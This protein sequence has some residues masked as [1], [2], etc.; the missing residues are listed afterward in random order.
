M[1][2]KIL[3]SIAGLIVLLLLIGF[4]LPARLHISKSVSIHAPV[5]AVFE[6]INDLKRWE[7]WQYWNTLD[8]KMQIVYGE[9]TVGTGASYSWE[10]PVL[11]KGN[12]TISESVPDKSVA[13]TMDFGGNPTSGLYTVESDNGNTKLNFNFYADQGMNPIGRWIN[14]FMK[15]EIEKSF[16]YAGEKIK[17]IAEAKP[18]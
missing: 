15:G 5:S 11:D 4:V 14:V 10:G 6:E 16:D 18:K 12:L 9:K 8:P 17:A 13:I 2:K 3:F 7:D 1:I